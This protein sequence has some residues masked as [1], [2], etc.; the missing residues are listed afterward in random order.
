MKE[1][2]EVEEEVAEAIEVVDDLDIET[3]ASHLVFSKEMMTLKKKEHTTL[4][5]QKWS[6]ISVEI[7]ATTRMSATLSYQK[8][9][10][11]SQNFVEKKEEETFLMAFHA[12]IETH[13][14]TWYVDTDCNN[15][16]S[17]Y[18]SSFLN[19]DLSFH[20]VVSFGDKST[21]K[22]MGKG[23]IQIKTKND[24]IET[25]SNVFLYS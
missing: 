10:E 12:L 23:D 2:D 5:S 19:L 9:K 20:T 7:L 1:V 21:M 17:G 25:I 8:K 11:K 15:C 6:V 4:I 22:M 13:Q 18:K 3:I 24:F 16:M 14:E